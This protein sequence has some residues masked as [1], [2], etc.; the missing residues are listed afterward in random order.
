M[1]FVSF[2]SLPFCLLEFA[3]FI[4]FCGGVFCWFWFVVFFFPCLN[5]DQLTLKISKEKEGNYF[6]SE[7]G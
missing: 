6:F 4:S 7:L 2:L 5:C 3:P 1:E